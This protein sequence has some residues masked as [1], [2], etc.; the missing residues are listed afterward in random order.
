VH[1][2]GKA[3]QSMDISENELIQALQEALTPSP[4]GAVGLTTVQLYEE[5]NR[6]K[7]VVGMNKLRRELRALKEAGV[8]KLVRF[9]IINLTEQP[10]T[11]SGWVFN[12]ASRD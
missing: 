10:Q 11:V 3:G 9:Q 8:V 1:L 12:D 7:L 2:Q 5:L 6:E 4:G